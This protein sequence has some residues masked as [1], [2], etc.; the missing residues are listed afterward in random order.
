MACRRG[1]TSSTPAQGSAAQRGSERWAAA[2]GPCHPPLD[3]AAQHSMGARSGA[4]WGGG[5]RGFARQ[6]VDW[7]QEDTGASGGPSTALLIDK[8]RAAVVALPPHPACGGSA[9]DVQGSARRLTQGA[10]VKGGQQP[11]VGVEGEAVRQLQAGKVVLL[12]GADGR[13][14]GVCC[15]HVQPGAVPAGP[16]GE[17]ET[18]ALPAHAAYTCSQVPCLQGQGSGGETRRS[19]AREWKD[20]DVEGCGAAARTGNVSHGPRKRS[21]R[22]PTRS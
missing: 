18:A 14:A 13:A 2:A 22:S 3:R 19:S 9:A 11:L 7:K 20:R 10:A 4:G 16:G 12:L 21:K 17:G 5:A 15:I 1:A 6:P 8:A